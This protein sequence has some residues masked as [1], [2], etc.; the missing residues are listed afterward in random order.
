MIYDAFNF[1][2]FCLEVQNCWIH[3]H[4]VIYNAFNFKPFGWSLNKTAKVS[5]VSLCM[6]VC[7]VLES[8]AM[9]SAT[10]K[11]NVLGMDMLLKRK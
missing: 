7:S 2:P 5:V 11:H 10:A 6:H 9:S 4:I 3:T 1:K 8:C